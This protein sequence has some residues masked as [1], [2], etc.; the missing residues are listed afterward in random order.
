M[1]RCRLALTLPTDFND[2]TFALPASP[3]ILVLL[4]TAGLVSLDLDML[5]IAGEVELEPQPSSCG[6]VKNN[7]FDMSY[8]SLLS[9]NTG[10]NHD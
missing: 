6:D 10:N 2:F 5:P 8:R 7:G 1:A 4:R 9:T 3:A